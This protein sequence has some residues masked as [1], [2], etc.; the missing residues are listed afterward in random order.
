MLLIVESAVAREV[1][2][3]LRFDNALVQTLQIDHVFTGAGGTLEELLTG[4]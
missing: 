3:P 2:V 4:L 1:S